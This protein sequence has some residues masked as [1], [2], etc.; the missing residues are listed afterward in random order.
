MEYLE[1]VSKPA[2]EGL[3]VGKSD[4]SGRFTSLLPGALDVD[5]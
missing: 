1:A 4:E 5:P 2:L 3:K